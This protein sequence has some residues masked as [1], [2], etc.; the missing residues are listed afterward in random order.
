MCHGQGAVC[1]TSSALYVPVVE[2]AIQHILNNRKM[3]RFSNL[4]SWPSM[5]NAGADVSNEVT[6]IRVIRGR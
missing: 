4:L 5:P 3:V 6:V 2:K 1:D